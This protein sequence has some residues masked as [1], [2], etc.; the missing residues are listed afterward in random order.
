MGETLIWLHYLIFNY[1]ISTVDRCSFG[2]NKTI[3]V[4]YY[5]KAKK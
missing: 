2:D 3:N 4:L 5:K 1:S